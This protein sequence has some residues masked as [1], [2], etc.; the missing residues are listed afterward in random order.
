MEYRILNGQIIIND[1]R[2][3]NPRHILESGQT[4]RYTKTETG[5]KIFAKNLFCSL[6][7]DNDRVIMCSNH[8]DYFVN[9]FDLNRDYGKIKEALNSFPSLVEAVNFGSGIRI[10]NQDPTE[11]IFSFIIS[12]NNNIPRIKLIINRLCDAL[13]EEM[14]GYRAFPTVQ[15]LASKD[16]AFYRSLG[17]GYR[18]KYIGKTAQR[19]LDGFNLNLGGMT[20]AEAK[21][22]LLKLAGVGPKVADCILL[23][24]YHRTDA[25]PTDVW[26]ERV[27]DALYGECSLNREAKSQCLAARFGSLSGYAQQY[28][29]YYAR[30]KNIISSK[31]MEEKQ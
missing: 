9:Y 23:F 20:T 30:E 6:I 26:I 16:E 27:Y 10:L 24:A 19:I 17:L 4:F 15:A 28:L 21:K 8:A 29:F 1:T 25:F 2:E 31:K 7:Y 14:D 18:A 12:A 3:F 22:H 13:G 5:Y 11:T